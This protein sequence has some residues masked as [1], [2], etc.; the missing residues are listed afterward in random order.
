[1]IEL[2]VL[3]AADKAADDDA[4]A[5]AGRPRVWRSHA[6][7]TNAP[8]TAAQRRA[9]FLPGA[10]PDAADGEDAGP[11][12]RS[13]LKVMGAS[14]AMAGLT[15]CRRPVE[16]VL[17]YVRKPESIIPG[18]ANYFA[19]AMP[20]NGVA[21]ALLV[22]SHEGR[23]TKVEGNPDHPVSQGATGAFA[24]ASVLTLYDPDRSRS[25]WREGQR[26]GANG[27]G[28]FV[29]AAAALRAA[30]TPVAVLAGPTP[31]PTEARLREQ[32][33]AAA[34]G[35]RVITLHPHGDDPH[36]LGTQLAF[37]RPLRP[38]VRFSQADVVVSLDAD[39][40]GVD[41]LN[42]VADAREYAASRRLEERGSMSRLYVAE[43]SYSTTGGMADHRLRM[44]AG[45][46]ALFAAAVAR[47]LGVDTG[48]PA[49]ELDG[50]AEAVAAAIASDVQAAG[51]RAVFVAGQT[52][53]PEVHALCAALNGRFGQAAVRYYDTGAE[54]VEP[55]GPQLRALVAD[56]A[57]GRVPALVMLGTNPVYS[58]PQELG[59]AEALA[60]VPLSIH[61]GLWRDETAQAS[62]WHVPSS[63]YLESWGDGRAYDGTL[64]IV[65]PLIAPLYDD[66]HSDLEVLGAMLTGR[67]VSGYDLVREALSDRVGGT[68]GGQGFE[69]QWRT[70]VHD[71]FLPGTQ[72]P[73]VGGGAASAPD[74]SG[75][76][77]ATPDAIE[78]VF[79]TSPTVFDGH[80]ANNAWMQE[81]PHPTTKIVWDN[82]ALMS[83][84]TADRLGVAA[85]TEKANVEADTV[86]IAVAGGAEAEVPVFV[87][88]GHP[89]NSITVQLG[90]GRAIE[91]ERQIRELGF[92]NKLTFGSAYAVD[93]NTDIYR[94]GP[95]GNG[96]GTRVEGLR[97]ANFFAV[98]PGVDVDPGEGDHRIVSTQDH[99]LMEGR[100]IVRFSTV[101]EYRA[102]PTMAKDEG[103]YIEETPWEQFP[104]LW[105]EEN[106]A[107]EQIEDLNE[108]NPVMYSDQQW[109]MAID[110][111]TCHGCNA[112]VVACTS[113]NN[114]QVV[115]KDQVAVG[116]EMSWLRMDRYYVG[117]G[118]EEAVDSE[119][120]NIDDDDVGMVTMPMLCQHCEN[121][122]CEQVCPVAATV[123]SPDGTNAM[124]YNRC[125]GTR[126]CAN[127]CP[128]KV[129]RYNF[130]NW[131]KTL[132]IEVQMAQNPN[133]TVRFRGVMEKCT[134][135][136]HR[137]RKVQQLAHIESREL[138]DGAVQ[139]ACQ[140]ACPT[141]AITFGDVSD[142][143]SAVTAQRQSPR[144]YAVLAELAVKPRTTYLARLRNPHPDLAAYDPFRHT[145]GHH[146]DTDHGPA[147]SQHPEEAEHSDAVSA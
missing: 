120:R 52:Q 98:Q 102:M 140:Q 57:A 30:G 3:S 80:Y 70:V 123:H 92:L 101:D 128:Y 96:V 51:G 66:A 55:V 85:E 31:S 74:L 86:R 7:R 124:I 146:G 100:S 114:V 43:S 4:T 27:W 56:M 14:M 60:R 113:E 22:E 144:N 75:L 24:Q 37:G 5:A 109:G 25:V 110:L 89:D 83:R 143:S 65:Q 9:E 53:R 68:P 122:P 147:D 26:I 105:G 59:F 44:K 29:T 41:S 72:F 61:T 126:Y 131:T 108:A 88:P 104:P 67:S 46:V 103:H 127:N 8:G 97:S 12:R 112:C 121:A 139:T 99:G 23:P 79:R 84:A 64:S 20:H 116:R 135:C 33:L 47:R 138:E 119:E 21:E 50:R 78:L 32:L 38:T 145:G 77:A 58:L 11:S 6:D 90:Y 134:F 1:M 15:A 137:V 48:A 81:T 35:S 76:E 107:A 130:F 28:A 34:P 87:Q 95:V 49:A 115:G 69:N 62:T 133:V 129:R 10:V 63:H 117:G 111:N 141:N 73:T 82:V 18:V 19:T 2:D 132:P 71:G 42:Y 54:P 142:A 106:G 93:E 136:I 40:L 94:L 13:F 17:P 118:S 91:T 125:I 16:E 39:F 36:A 45:N